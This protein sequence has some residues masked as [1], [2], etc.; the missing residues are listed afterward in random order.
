MTFNTLVKSKQ[1]EVGKWP[2]SSLT[3]LQIKS[4]TGMILTGYDISVCVLVQGTNYSNCVGYAESQ[5][6]YK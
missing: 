4:Y 1:T 6:S 2:L 5:A 3:R